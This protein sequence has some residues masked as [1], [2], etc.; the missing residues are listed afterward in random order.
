V[1]SV[2][3]TFRACELLF[4]TQLLLG[5]SSAIIIIDVAC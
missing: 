1:T 2:L 4:E 3:A 5:S